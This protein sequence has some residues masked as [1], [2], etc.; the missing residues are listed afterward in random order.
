M[1]FDDLGLFIL[2]FVFVFFDLISRGAWV[3]GFGL[4]LN[5]CVMGAG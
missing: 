5:R 3:M 2:F 1:K 4:L